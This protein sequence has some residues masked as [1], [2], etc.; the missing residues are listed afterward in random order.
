MRAEEKV[1]IPHLV[2]GYVLTTA[3]EG[4]RWMLRG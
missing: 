1:A 3:T 4:G 2:G